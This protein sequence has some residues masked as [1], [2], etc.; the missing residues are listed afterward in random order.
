MIENVSTVLGPKC[1]LIVEDIPVVIRLVVATEE[2]LTIENFE[3]IQA[4][5]RQ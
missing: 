2:C 1:S 4:F 3:Y 5:K